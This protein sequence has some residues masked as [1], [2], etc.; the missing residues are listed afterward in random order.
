MKKKNCLRLCHMQWDLEREEGDFL[1]SAFEEGVHRFGSSGTCDSEK[2]EE[3][4]ESAAD[5]VCL[6]NS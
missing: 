5:L 2:R 6:R 4:S 1:T 3:D